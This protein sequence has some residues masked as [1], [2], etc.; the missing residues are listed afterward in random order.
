MQLSCKL[1]KNSSFPSTWLT[2]PYL[3]SHYPSSFLI[4]TF[5]LSQNLFKLSPRLFS[6]SFNLES[7]ARTLTFSPNHNS[8]EYL[9]TIRPTHFPWSTEI[10]YT[11]SSKSANKASFLFW[12]RKSILAKI[13]VGGFGLYWAC[14]IKGDGNE[15]KQ[16]GRSGQ[17]SG[18]GTVESY[19]G[20]GYESAF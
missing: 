14:G 7:L 18:G 11:E 1:F 2:A 8:V 17:M 12:P 6:P 3:L 15:R 20:F 13:D 19:I 4:F 10:K 9:I 5:S 16:K